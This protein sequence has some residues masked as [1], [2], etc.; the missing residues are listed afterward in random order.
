MKNSFNDL[1]FNELTTKREEIKKKYFD[2]RFNMVI[3]HVDNTL[4]KRNIRR[5]LAR[6]NT[7]IHEYNLGIR[8]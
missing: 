3:G 6:L 5:A 7:L 2:L 4:E 1:T 8:K